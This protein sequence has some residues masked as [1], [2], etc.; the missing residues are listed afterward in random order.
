MWGVDARLAS[1]R[2]ARLNG[3]VLFQSELSGA[4]LSEAHLEGTSLKVT[5]DEQTLYGPLTLSVGG[6]SRKLD[7]AELARWLNDRGAQVEVIGS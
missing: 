1:F 6:L 4:D 2:G 5:F 3:A 7:G